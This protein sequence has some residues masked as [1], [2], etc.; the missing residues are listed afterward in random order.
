MIEKFNVEN[1]EW[2]ISKEVIFEIDD[3]AFARGGFRI[4]YEAKSDD[5]SFRENAWVVNKYSTSSKETFEKMGEAYE[6]HSKKAVQ[7]NCFARYFS[8][9]FSK[10][11]LKVYEDFGDC[12]K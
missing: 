1:N 11:F 4:A 12:F 7:M 10:A 2:S 5:E 3:K 9:S 8:F 6:S